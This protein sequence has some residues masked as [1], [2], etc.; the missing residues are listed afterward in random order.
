MNLNILK[1]ISARKA[2]SLDQ[3]PA[4]TLLRDLQWQSYFWEQGF[5][6]VSPGGEEGSARCSLFDLPSGCPIISSTDN[7]EL[8][9]SFTSEESKEEHLSA[10]ILDPTTIGVRFCRSIIGTKGIIC[11]HQCSTCDV[12]SHKKKSILVLLLYL[13]RALLSWTQRKCLRPHDLN[14]VK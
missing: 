6:Q 11:I 7:Q 9:G 10:T 2:L 5:L 4:N 8:K 1:Y 14:L 12:I 3:C 13:L